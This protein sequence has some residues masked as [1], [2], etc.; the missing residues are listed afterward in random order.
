MNWKALEIPSTSHRVWASNRVADLQVLLALKVSVDGHRGANCC[1]S[2]CRWNCSDIVGTADKTWRISKFY[3]GLEKKYTPQK[4]RQWFKFH[5]KMAP[6]GKRRFRLWKLGFPASYLNEHGSRGIGMMGPDPAET[7]QISP[8][9]LAVSGDGR[10]VERDRMDVSKET[11]QKIERH[12]RIC[13]VFVFRCLRCLEPTLPSWARV[14]HLQ[15]FELS[16]S[17]QCTMKP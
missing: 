8:I 6:F 9:W 5:L 3:L 15:S 7:N 17:R 11:P 4:N 12:F 1:G 14:F 16:S 10:F 13:L 2:C